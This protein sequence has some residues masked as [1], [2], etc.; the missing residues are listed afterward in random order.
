MSLPDTPRVAFAVAG[1]ASGIDFAA[2]EPRFQIIDDEYGRETLE[3]RIYWR[4][5]HAAGGSPHSLRLDI[6]RNE[7]VAFD[8]VLLCG[9]S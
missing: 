2:S 8:P 9:M 5:P 6:T 7:V 4:G 1:R 3:F